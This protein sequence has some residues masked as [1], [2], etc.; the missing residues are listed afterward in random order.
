[1]RFLAFIFCCA[2]LI[3]QQTT[4]AQN[5]T[6]APVSCPTWYAVFAAY[7]PSV[8][9]KTTAGG[10]VAT[11]LPGVTCAA[12]FQAYSYSQYVVTAARVAGVWTLNST[13]T[14]GV[15]VPMRGLGPFE[16]WALG[17]AGVAVAGSNSA[18]KLGSTYG[19]M[20]TSPPITKIGVTVALAFERV[21][22]INTGLI[23]ITRSFK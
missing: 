1:M 16:V 8:S 4:P 13:T 9:P 5:P 18:L 22:G 3:A 23:G 6:A 15:A 11:L 7:T 12:G 17:A 21:N 14:S 2:P 10:A 19:G 20:I